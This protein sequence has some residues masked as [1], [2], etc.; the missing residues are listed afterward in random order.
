MSHCENP[1]ADPLCCTLIAEGA[2]QLGALFAESHL[3]QYLG[4]K[5]LA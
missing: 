2:R 4:N 5:G 3:W 1:T